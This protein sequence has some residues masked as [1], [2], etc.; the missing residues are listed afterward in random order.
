MGPDLTYLNIINSCKKMR[1]NILKM[2]YKAGNIGA[3]VGGSL[4]LV[5]IMAAL[6]LR[7]MN[8]DKDLLCSDE[9]DRLILSKGHGVMAQYA[10]MV[11]AGIIPESLLSHFKEDSGILSAHPSMNSSLGIEFSSGSLG[12]G[13][14][15]GVGSALAMRHQGKSKQKVFVVLGDGECDEGQVW[16]SAMTA[17]HYGLGNLIC[18]VD[19]NHLQ[20]DGATEEVKSKSNLADIWNSFG[21]MVHECNGHDVKKLCEI[22]QID[23]VGNGKP[24]VVIAHTVKGKGVSFM[25]CQAQ[26]H[27]SRLSEEQLSLAIEEVVNN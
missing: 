24:S 25:E 1:V 13:L 7:V 16:E 14:S 17:S 12:Q 15:L 2:T 22:L 11:E 27:N 19:C 20:Y 10:A 26:W 21:W 3:H 4:S 5:E 8:I 18:I 9:R 6:Y 23:S